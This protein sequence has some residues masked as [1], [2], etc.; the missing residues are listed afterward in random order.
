ML[1]THEM[2]REYFVFYFPYELSKREQLRL[3]YSHFLRTLCVCVC[4]KFMQLC[5]TL[6]NPMDGSLPQMVRF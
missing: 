2:Q 4:V 3:L 6:C 5:L 1:Q